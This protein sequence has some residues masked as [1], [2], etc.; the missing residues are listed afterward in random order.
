[1]GHYLFTATLFRCLQ[2][3]IIQ[4]RRTLHNRLF[5]KNHIKSKDTGKFFCQARERAGAG[6]QAVLGKQRFISQAPLLSPRLQA[7]K[8]NKG[9]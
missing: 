9:T 5:E 6:N 2:K 1:M 3:P 7:Y 4:I 8:C